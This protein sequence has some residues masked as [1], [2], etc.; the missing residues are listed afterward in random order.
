[1][2]AVCCRCIHSCNGLFSGIIQTFQKEYKYSWENF[3]LSCVNHCKY[4]NFLEKFFC[5]SFCSMQIS[6]S[7]R[8][9]KS[10]VS[11]VFL[12]CDSVLPSGGRLTA[13]SNPIEHCPKISLYIPTG[14]L[15]SDIPP[16]PSSFLQQKCMWL[17]TNNLLNLT[18][19]R[20]KAK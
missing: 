3:Q 19:G 8:S 1:M 4:S 9:K 17:L 11:S 13:Y 7:S 10:K 5:C 20:L 2:C 14:S 18:T 15:Q 6:W 16:P 12:I